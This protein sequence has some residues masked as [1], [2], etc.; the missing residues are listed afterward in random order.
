MRKLSMI[1][2]AAG[3]GLVAYW[4]L[5]SGE[6]TPQAAVEGV[7]P[8]GESAEMVAV[9]LPEFSAEAER[10]QGYFGAVCATCHGPKAGGIDSKGPP[11]VHRLYVPGHHSDQ[12]IVMAARRGVQ[13]HHWRFGNMPVIEGLTDGDLR[14]IIV[15][16]REVQRAN[17]IS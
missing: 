10:G 4:V 5:A 8:S 6:P 2:I 17:G 7:V 15:F 13:S 3:I 1:V 11:L 14:D 12:A 9:T 16:L